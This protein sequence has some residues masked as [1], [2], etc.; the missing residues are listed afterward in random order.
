MPTWKH[1]HTYTQFH[2]IRSSSSL[3]STP[4]IVYLGFLYISLTTLHASP[5]HIKHLFLLDTHYLESCVLPRLLSFTVNHSL[6]RHENLA[7][8]STTDQRNDLLF[9]LETRCMYTSFILT[10]NK[11]VVIPLPSG[12]TAASRRVTKSFLLPCTHTCTLA[13]THTHSP[14]HWI[15]EAAKMTLQGRYYSCAT[16][17]QYSTLK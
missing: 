4:F 14:T 9:F 13:H 1:T 11:E 16:E 2:S 10:V 17:I 6:T 8:V 5:S 15:N 12:H 3:Q 7:F